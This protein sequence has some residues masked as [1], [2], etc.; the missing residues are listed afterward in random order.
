M[1][2]SLINTF[3]PHALVENGAGVVPG[4]C[5]SLAVRVF[6]PQDRSSPATTCVRSGALLIATSHA[7]WV[8]KVNPKAR[9]L[10][11]LLAFDLRL[12]LYR[13]GLCLFIM[14]I[15]FCSG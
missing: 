11:C 4:P 7:A 13:F 5:L 14:S 8:L 3:D 1:A 15:H 6:P 9:N 10:S 12:I 2:S